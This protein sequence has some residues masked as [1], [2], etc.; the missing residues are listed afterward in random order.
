QNQLELFETQSLEREKLSTLVDRLS[1]RLG[2]DAVTR[3]SLVADAQPEYAYRFDPMISSSNKVKSKRQDRRRSPRQIPPC[4]PRLLRRPLR[5]WPT[6]MPIQAVSF[7]PDGPPIRFRWAGEDYRIN[8]SW[9]PE[10]VETGWW[11]ANDIQRDYYVV[12]T[13]L[14]NRFW[15]F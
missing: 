14:G 12:M 7:I 11:R 15:I 1:N 10:R 2:C 13:H 5:L 8:R 6:P 9:G 3:A 4:E